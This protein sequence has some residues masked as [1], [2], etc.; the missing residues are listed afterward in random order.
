[1]R[2]SFPSL[3]VLFFL[4]LSTSFC[5]AAPK[6]LLPANLKAGDTVALITP[7][8]LI[9][10]Q[11]LRFSVERME[12]LGLRV[13]L[14]N[15]LLAK[16]DFF[17]GDIDHRAEQINAAIHD[18]EVKALIAVRG[19]YG[20]TALLDKIDYDAIKKHPKIIMGYSDLTVLLLAINSK[21]GLL[22]FHGP[23]AGQAWPNYSVNYV[24][25]VLFDGDK[26]QFRNPVTEEDD[27]IQTTWRTKTIYSGTVKGQLIGGNLTMITTFIGNKHFP[28]DWRGKILFLEDI[29]ENTLRL[30]RSMLQLQKLGILSEIAG[31]VFG[32]CVSC[33][34]ET[35]RSPTIEKIMSD[36]IKPLKIPA[37][38]G[39]A[40]GHQPEQLTLPIGAMVQLDA[41]KGEIR[42]LEKPVKS[43]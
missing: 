13:K 25:Q 33:K 32:T 2:R 4:I 17:A 16:D 6:T 24:K 37:Y 43:S 31:F 14:M 42:L 12:A 39:A 34:S 22:T 7:G 28:S 23:M 10:D 15:N 26:P 8:S 38:M 27:L 5:I 18:P 40:I 1:M 30:H 3:L 29:G 11:Q 20:T 41:D 36:Y 9:T 35:D 19:G 21:T